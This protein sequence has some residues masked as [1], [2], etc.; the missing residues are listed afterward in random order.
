M[1]RPKRQRPAWLPNW[2]PF[3]DGRYLGLARQ[4]IL[5]WASAILALSFFLLTVCYASE[6][7]SISHLKFVRSSRSNTIL[8]LRILSEAAAL[9]L[10]A[11]IHSTFEVVQ[12]VLISRP[13]GI[14]LSQYLALQS[15]TGP[16]GLIALALGAGLSPAQ[17]P[18]SPRVLSLLRL[19]AELTVPV[20]GVLI[21]GRVNVNTLYAP[22]EGTMQPFAFGMEPFNS[23]VAFQLG[24]MQD[25]LF[26]LNYVTFLSDPSHAVNLAP[27]RGEDQGC[28]RGLSL[29]SNK[30]CS[31]RVLIVQEY[32]NV[33]ATLPLAKDSTSRYHAILSQNQHVYSLEYQDNVNIAPHSNLSCEYFR[34]G[35]SHYRLCIGNA[36][37]H[38]LH[39]S[40]TPCPA[41]LVRQAKC[42]AKNENWE[43]AHTFTTAL[44][45][46]TQLATIAYNRPSGYILSH[47]LK[48][49]AVP[50]KIDASDF[51][52]AL[53]V[54]LNTTIPDYIG[55]DSANPI[56]GVPTQF[57]GRLIAAQ[58][59]RYSEIMEH[60]PEARLRGVNALQSLLAMTLFYCQN[61]VLNNTIYA[62]N[63]QGQRRLPKYD[64]GLFDGSDVK[65]ATVAQA[66]TRYKI[67][68]GR[69]TLVAYI[70]LS[71]ATLLICFCVLAVGSLMELAKFDAEP[72]LW[73]AF[74]FWTQCRV[75]DNSGKV[76]TAQD[77][78]EMA[79][80][81][82]GRE[83]FR[84][85]GGLNVTRRK[86]KMRGNA[87]LELPGVRAQ[88]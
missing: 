74:D 18:F 72:T 88:D 35:P 23:S 85:V 78:T 87:E 70:V 59:Y 42:A 45:P 33:F 51:L 60:N 49:P 17:W 69:D 65:N 48:S 71:G 25:L 32:Q 21:M 26:N 41:A 28:V 1:P 31:L 10:S 62:R 13:G 7:S 12:W 86:R 2:V 46:S 39:A 55:V 57:F 77:R 6:R 4:T 9:F 56:L 15:S 81:Y 84:A 11:T 52:L 79:W 38:W 8:V 36:A 64:V 61:G 37:D 54:I 3:K 67:E 76:V 44:K 82:H 20:L 75:E 40:L 30:S 83:L 66:E 22:I 29:A 50:A 34:S 19:L 68:V 53:R 27:E 63:Q 16:L 5:A 80:I 14:R 24:V 43:D 58:M 73:P 47:D